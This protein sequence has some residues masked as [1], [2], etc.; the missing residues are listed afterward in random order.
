MTMND[1]QIHA[2]NGHECMI[3]QASNQCQ[4][5]TS[6]SFSRRMV[7]SPVNRDHCLN[8]TLNSNHPVYHSGLLGMVILSGLAAV[9]V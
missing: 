5:I 1:I 4:E 8:V 2:V 3:G 7:V 6:H 9:L